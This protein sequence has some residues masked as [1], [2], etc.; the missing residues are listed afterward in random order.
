[1]FRFWNCVV[2]L[3][4]SLT[5]PPLV[6]AQQTTLPS[7]LLRASREPVIFAS[8]LR[9]AVDQATVALAGFQAGGD[10]ISIEQA[11]QSARNAYVLIR[12]ARAGMI[13]KKEARRFGDAVLDHTIQRTTEAWNLARTPVDAYTF[14]L[15][16]QEYRSKSIRALS[17]AL[18]IL[19][20]VL[21]G[22]P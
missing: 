9:M 12:S 3:V 10:S 7:S 18:T 22:M 13:L 2:A 5:L 4:V 17:E 1:M 14:G 19:E 11:V 15:T 20:L 8:Q 6:H 16:R 21:A